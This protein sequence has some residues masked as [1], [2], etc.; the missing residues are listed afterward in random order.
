[1]IWLVGFAVG[2]L[3]VIAIQCIQMNS[4][5]R[6]IQG[7]LGDVFFIRQAAVSQRDAARTMLE[8]L[9]EI[10]KHT[11]TTAAPEYERQY[12]LDH[13]PWGQPKDERPAGSD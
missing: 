3:L 6:S 9:K 8:T 5:L 7:L 12:E 4:S 1:M 10:E 2:I 13:Y 11:A